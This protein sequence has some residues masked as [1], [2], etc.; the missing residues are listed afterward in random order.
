MQIIRGKTHTPRRIVLFGPNFTGKSTQASHFPDNLFLDI[1]SSL[2]DIDCVKTE[3]LESIQAVYDAVIEVPKHGFKWL[4]IDSIDWVETLIQR[5]VAENANVPSYGDKTFEYG[6][7]Q[8]LCQPY[9][10]RLIKGLDWLTKKNIGIILIA[11]EKKVSIKPVD[12]EEYQ[13]IEPALE[14][15]ARNKICDWCTELLYIEPR[16]LTRSIDTGFNKK[17]QLAVGGEPCRVMQTRLTTG[18]RA[19]NRLNLPAEIQMND[20]DLLWRIIKKTAASM[21]EEQPQVEAK[22]ADIAGIV[23]DGSSKTKADEA[24]EDLEKQAAEVF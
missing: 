15:T 21:L 6:R 3:R 14:D 7:G 5:Q 10:D 23:I 9:W 1:E 12:R 8:K 16:M 17:R 24:Y 20:E 22:G 19:K 11:H 18:V 2:G 13:R 4:T